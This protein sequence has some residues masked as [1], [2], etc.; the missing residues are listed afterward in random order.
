MSCWQAFRNAAGKLPRACEWGNLIE[1]SS[2]FTKFL[3]G[4]TPADAELEKLPLDGLKK[5]E[6]FLQRRLCHR[7]RR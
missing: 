7:S 5:L 1:G 2:C 3:E 4:V 6:Q